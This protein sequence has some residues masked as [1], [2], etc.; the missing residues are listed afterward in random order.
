MAPLFFAQSGFVLV[1]L[2]CAQRKDSPMIH[3]NRMADLDLIRDDPE[4]W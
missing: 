3:I 2:F 4:L 1:G